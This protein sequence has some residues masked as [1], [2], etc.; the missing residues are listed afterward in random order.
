MGAYPVALSADVN[1]DCGRYGYKIEVPPEVTRSTTKNKLTYPF[2]QDKLKMSK[3]DPWGPGCLLYPFSWSRSVFKAGIKHWCNSGYK[4]TAVA[5]MHKSFDNTFNYFG[6][7]STDT[8]S[9]TGLPK[10]CLG[11]AKGEYEQ[12]YSTCNAATAPQMGNSKITVAV[13]PS[14]DQKDCLPLG[15][16]R[17]P[18]GEACE[19]L[20]EPIV[21][22]CKLYLDTQVSS[23]LTMSRHLG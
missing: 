1:V 22:Q 17:L 14:A 9:K 4:D 16:F 15:D 13:I 11:M 23:C 5:N 21:D 3:C 8:D 2:D 18:S 12:W 20:L 7:D 10:R 19:K 6:F